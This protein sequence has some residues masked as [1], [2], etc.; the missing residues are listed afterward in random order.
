[1]AITTERTPTPPTILHDDS[2]YA[3]AIRLLPAGRILELGSSNGRIAQVLS[4]R[5]H[6][7]HL[8][9]IDID[10]QMLDATPM[11][12]YEDLVAWD[13]N[14]GQPPVDGIFDGL[15]ALDVLEHVIDPRAVLASMHSL[16]HPGSV[17]V[18]GV[19]NW[20]HYTNRL[21]ILAGKWRYDP[22]GGLYDATHLR[23]YSL[24]NLDQLVPSGFRITDITAFGWMPGGSRLSR[25]PVLLET[26]RVFY[27]NVQRPLVRALPRLLSSS[28]LVQLRTT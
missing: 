11:G 4:T 7:I 24:G 18:I 17:V 27:G 1:V 21:R 28:L 26:Y 13:L 25:R 15:L 16:L 19:P 8:T 23:F 22:C 3:S 10:R 6:D 20:L 2:Y 14:A 12:L 9:G 5:R